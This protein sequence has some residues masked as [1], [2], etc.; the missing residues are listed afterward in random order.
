MQLSKVTG[1]RLLAL[2]GAVGLLTAPALARDV[3]VYGGG[4]SRVVETGTDRPVKVIAWGSDRQ[5]AYDKRIERFAL[6]RKVQ[7][8]LDARDTADEIA[9]SDA[10]MR[11]MV[12]GNKDS[13]KQYSKYYPYHYR[14][15]GFYEQLKRAMREQRAGVRVYR[16]S[17]LDDVSSTDLQLVVDALNKME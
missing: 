11:I 13:R 6:E 15:V 7:K 12:R 9:V 10:L 5:T 2:I 17:V 14:S 8:I 16:Q 3:T 1:P 4:K